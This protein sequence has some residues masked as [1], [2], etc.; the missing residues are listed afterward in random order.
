MFVAEQRVDSIGIRK[1]SAAHAV[2]GTARNAEKSLSLKFPY[3]VLNDKRDFKT[4]L[5]ILEAKEKELSKKMKHTKINYKKT[6]D[7]KKKDKLKVLYK[8]IKSQLPKIEKQIEYVKINIKIKKIEKLREKKKEKSYKKEQFD[9]LTSQLS[10]LTFFMKEANRGF[11][12][13]SKLQQKKM[14]NAATVTQQSMTPITLNESKDS[15]LLMIN[16]SNEALSQIQS[17]VTPSY[18]Q[19]LPPNMGNNFNQWSSSH[20]QQGPPPPIPFSHVHL[21]PSYQQQSIQPQPYYPV[22]VAPPTS[23]PPTASSQPPPQPKLNESYI[24]DPVKLAE[25]IQNSLSIAIVQTAA[26]AHA[27]AAITAVAINP[28]PPPTSNIG[29]TEPISVL[30][31][32]HEIDK[33]STTFENYKA[34]IKFLLER[35]KNIVKPTNSL[36]TLITAYKNDDDDDDDDDD[37]DDKANEGNGM[38]IGDEEVNDD[39]EDDSAEYSSDDSE[40]EINIILK[41]ASTNLNFVVPSTNKIYGLQASRRYNFDKY[42]LIDNP[43]DL[44]YERNTKPS[45]LIAQSSSFSVTCMG[46]SSILTKNSSLKNILYKKFNKIK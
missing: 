18:Y 17:T 14:N 8:T 26:A 30:P 25:Y 13:E 11:L 45:L 44:V 5:S 3:P 36:K 19:Q 2:K 41:S 20:Q 33:A 10:R 28:P 39:A 46:T 16:E 21:G 35:D 6:E 38:I 34:K 12:N 40:T 7:N 32:K 43:N 37:G 31:T 9:E 27:H 42:S 1:M 23:Q 24:S 15:D 22:N 4:I 29:T